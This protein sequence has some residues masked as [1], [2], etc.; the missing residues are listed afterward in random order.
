MGSASLLSS[1]SSVTTQSVISNSRQGAGS[2][3]TTCSFSSSRKI[4]MAR[5]SSY[6]RD[7]KLRQTMFHMPSHSSLEITEDAPL[8]EL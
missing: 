2:R 5:S 6:L 8:T 3:Y 4:A 1:M 7:P